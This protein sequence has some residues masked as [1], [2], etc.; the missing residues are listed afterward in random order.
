MVLFF[1]SSRRR[2]TS[3]YR[4]WSS[5]VCSSDLTRNS[6]YTEAASSS[7]WGRPPDASSVRSQQLLVRTD[8]SFRSLDQIGHHQPV[9][10]SG[11]LLPPDNV[12]AAPNGELAADGQ[13]GQ[14]SAGIGDRDQPRAEASIR[15]R[16]RKLGDRMRTARRH[17]LAGGQFA[18][19]RDPQREPD[20]L[21]LYLPGAEPAAAEMVTPATRRQPGHHLQPPTADRVRSGWDGGTN[22]Q[23]LAS[24]PARLGIEDLA[25]KLPARA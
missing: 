20:R 16:L 9:V 12:A 13:H 6:R 2:H 24:I 8:D 11:G 1:F 25:D 15:E 4:D 17:P 22:G 5:D 18:D 21:A 7:R 19:R 3:C 23:R 10:T 14:V